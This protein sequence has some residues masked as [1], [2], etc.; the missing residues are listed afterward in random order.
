MNASIGPAGHIGR[1]FINSKLT[2]LMVVGALALG[3][4]AISYT[5]REEEPQII[6]PIVDIFI[7]LP[8]GVPEEVENRITVPLEKRMWEIPGVEFVYSNSRPGGAMI[9]VRF[10]VGRRS[11][12]QSGQGLRQAGLRPRPHAGRCYAAAG[13]GADHR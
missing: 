5:P 2:P 6:V 11:G 10:L 3:A 7:G 13:Q 1:L 9:T 4:L 12:T 8:G